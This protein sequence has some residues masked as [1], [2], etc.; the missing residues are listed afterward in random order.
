MSND[1]S[2]IF[3]S[4]VG[5]GELERLSALETLKGL[6]GPE[7]VTLGELVRYL[8]SRG[9]WHQFAKIT[10]ADLREA[11]TEAPAPRSGPRKRKKKERILEDELGDALDAREA[12]AAED[13]KE[14]D[15]GGVSTDDVARRV[16]PFLEANGDVTLAEI[17]E[18]VKLDADFEGVGKRALRHHLNALVKEG[19]VERLGTGRHAVY[20]AL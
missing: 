9:L 1:A 2:A 8:D 19:R 16:M 11:F 12:A 5:Y 17:E 20:S 10:L 6:K 14:P 3:R 7:R 13:A 4:Q 18:Y 15:D